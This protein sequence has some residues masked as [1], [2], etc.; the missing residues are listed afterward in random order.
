MLFADDSNAFV[1]N[2]DINQIKQNSEK[3]FSKLE[4]CFAA[5]KLTLNLDNNNF[6]IFHPPRKNKITRM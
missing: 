1:I 4:E 5:N 2:K 3:L 6:N